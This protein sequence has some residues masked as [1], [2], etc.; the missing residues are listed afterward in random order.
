MRDSAV[1]TFD[2]TVQVVRDVRARTAEGGSSYTPG[3]VATVAGRH[4]AM[5][6]SQ[7]EVAEKLGIKGEFITLVPYDTDVQK[8]DH[9]IVGGVTYEVT[10]VLV[11]GTA[12]IKRVYSVT[13]P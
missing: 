7:L 3:T 6:A 9:L 8:Q 13:V 2:S 11:H 10:G 5:S 12:I 4:M 1:R